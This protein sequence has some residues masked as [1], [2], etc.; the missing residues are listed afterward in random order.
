MI[1]Q[2][3]AYGVSCMGVGLAL[4]FLLFYGKTY[5]MERAKAWLR[6]QVTGP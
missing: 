6:E 1:A 5:D 3:V 4:G 2:I